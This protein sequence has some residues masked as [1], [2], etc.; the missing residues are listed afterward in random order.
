MAD[1]VLTVGLAGDGAVVDFRVSIE[2]PRRD[3]EA[4]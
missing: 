3:V 1:D 4:I 2:G